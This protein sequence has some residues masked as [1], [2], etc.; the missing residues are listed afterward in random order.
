VSE[1]AFSEHE[2]RRVLDLPRQLVFCGTDQTHGKRQLLGGLCRLV[3]AVTG[4]AAMLDDDFTVV[5]EIT[6]VHVDPAE[7]AQ[8]AS[9]EIANPALPELFTPVPIETTLRELE[10][11]R[12]E[13]LR[14]ET[15]KLTLAT[16]ADDPESGAR[17]F[18]LDNPLVKP[19]I[20]QAA[21]RNLEPTALAR[22]EAV[23]DRQWYRSSFFRRFLAPMGLDDCILS[24]VPLPGMQ[25]FIAVVCLSGPLTRPTDR[26]QRRGAEAFFTP[27]QRRIVEIAHSQLRW[28]YYSQPA[29][30]EERRSASLQMICPTGP[31]LEKLAPRYQRILNHLLGGGSEKEVASQLGLSRFTVHEYIRAIYKQLNVNSRSELMARW[32]QT[33]PPPAV[34]A[35]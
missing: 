2:L 12:L 32:V 4:V 19:F 9:G 5:G 22:V 3:H 16:A 33:G 23:V 6:V 17:L 35:S 18:G 11:P 21:S 29:P 31:Q 26:R 30:V 20:Q 34:L 14:A 15:P 27:H 13:H 1:L 10:R 25:P 24:I 28:V 7:D 8:C